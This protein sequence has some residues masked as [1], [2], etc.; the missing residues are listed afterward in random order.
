[1]TINEVLEALTP[2]NARFVSGQNLYLYVPKAQTNKRYG[3]AK[4]SPDDFSIDSNGVLSLLLP[5]SQIEDYFDEIRGGTREET[6]IANPKINL[7]NLD[8]MD[9][10]L[11]NSIDDLYDKDKEIYGS[12]G[13][14]NTVLKGIDLTKLNERDNTLQDN[15]DYIIQDDRDDT[16]T[17]STYSANKIT[18]LIHE[19]KL[20]GLHF[21]GFVG[22]EVG[23]DHEGEAI[24]P[25]D[26][27]LWH[28]SDEA[29]V[30]SI[31]KQWD[32]DTMFIYSDGNWV[33][34]GEDYIP[35]DFAIW[36]NINLPD[37]E[38]N[39]WWWF[40]TGFEVLDF[41]VDM[42]LYYTKVESDARYKPMFTYGSYLSEVDKVL[43]ID[44]L[45]MPTTGKL[46]SFVQG[47]DSVLDVDNVEDAIKLLEK[48]TK[49]EIDIINARPFWLPFNET[50]TRLGEYS[51][52]TNG[53]YRSV[54][55]EEGGFEWQLVTDDLDTLL[56]RAN[57]NV[58]V[59]DGLSFTNDEETGY[60]LSKLSLIN[61]NT[62][63]KTNT[64][65]SVPVATNH[66]DGI[67]PATAMQALEE[68]DIKVTA[69]Q[70]G[71]Q[72]YFVDFGSDTPTQTALDLLYKNASGESGDIPNLT[73][74]I[75]AER[76]IYYEYYTSLDTHWQ[77]PFVYRYAIA[78]L[79]Q[80]GLVKSSEQ[81]GQIFVEPVNGVMSLNGYTD[82]MNT[83]N[84]LYGGEGRTQIDVNQVPSLPA[85]KITSGTLNS[86]R[87]PVVPVSKGGTNN[88]S[89]SA[90]K[91][92]VT[93]SVDE[94][95]NTANSL[96]DGPAFGSVDT[97]LAG[98]GA[99]QIPS[100]KSKSALDLQL[101][102]NK[103]TTTLSASNTDVQYPSAKLVFTELTTLSNTL[104]QSINNVSST[105]QQSINNVSS[106]LTS[107]IDTEISDRKSAI[108]SEATA[109]ENADNAL[110]ETLNNKTTVNINNVLQSTINFDS[111]PQ[112]QINNLN[113]TITN[114]Y[115]TLNSSINT[116]KSDLSSETTNRQ[117]ADTNLQNQI[118]S[119]NYWIKIDNP[120][121]S[122]VG[123]NLVS[124]DRVYIHINADNSLDF[125]LEISASGTTYDQVFGVL[126]FA[127]P[128]SITYNATQYN[129]A[130][131]VY[132][133]TENSL[134]NDYKESIFNYNGI[135]LYHL[136]SKRVSRTTRASVLGDEYYFPKNIT[137]KCL[138]SFIKKG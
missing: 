22:E 100:F 13:R 71:V 72:S 56:P 86:A 16:A 115:N 107:K 101:V 106:T 61:L 23:K 98:N 79:A 59:A 88:S 93:G 64:P 68:L 1:M 5:K 9:K 85:S 45:V 43:T 38:I 15:I 125:N 110:E 134:S 34:Y 40:E 135:K 83:F 6:V 75:D 8:A 137:I 126:T 102:S 17:D 66:T 73:R 60:F 116:T 104:Q 132:Q 95:D 105:L 111:D 62:E 78:S 32:A 77:G 55:N 136:Y 31:D 138:T 121:I 25:K 12:G 90:Y 10:E 51:V 131:K 63:E 119:I 2:E 18:K 120:G 46:T 50:P 58:N 117:N 52:T 84:T 49:D 11:Q 70:S 36:K 94:T 19:A 67:M 39:S 4:Y 29:S 129:L 65:I 33:P 114:N 14:E 48:N 24:T 130:D 122:V 87:L 76:N 109:R 57:A 124:I 133:V 44:N 47:T 41:N 74:L 99:N 112:T 26:G 7:L 89:F 20:E 127:L 53:V 92:V 80:I 28:V 54:V 118:N 81:K 123:N 103:V 97:I 108:T 37:S 69:L 30:P 42:S 91:L 35:E 82:I 27:I 113:T 3:L 21:V 96:N 128:Q